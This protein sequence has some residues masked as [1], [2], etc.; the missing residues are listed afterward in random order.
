MHTAG[1]GDRVQVGVAAVELGPHLHR[2]LRECFGDHIGVLG[3]EFTGAGRLIHPRQIVEH[4]TAVLLDEFL[5]R[6]GAAVGVQRRIDDIVH[7]HLTQ[8]I[9]AHGDI[10]LEDITETAQRVGDL[11]Q[12]R[13]LTDI[14]MTHLDVQH[15]LT[16]TGGGVTE[17]GDAAVEVGRTHVM[18]VHDRQPKSN[19]CSINEV[20]TV[21]EIKRQHKY[22]SRT[23]ARSGQ[24]RSAGGANQQRRHPPPC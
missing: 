7:I 6:I 1:G 20:L 12:P 21:R 22:S 9:G 24:T 13:Q 2:Q 15:R 3:G 23:N 5:L 10:G 17:G 14:T 4:R 16:H 8:L 18:K 19:M 11:L